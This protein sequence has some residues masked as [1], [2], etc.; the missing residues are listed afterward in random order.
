MKIK[1]FKAAVGDY[2]RAN[3][4]GQY[5]PEYGCLMFDKENGKIWTDEFYD[6]GHNAYK[7]YDSDTIINLGKIM[8][9]Q[10]MEINMKTVKEFINNNFDG[11]DD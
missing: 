5:S 4:K 7:V 6:L 11:F 2:K 3:K 1:G 8:S 9:E 10:G